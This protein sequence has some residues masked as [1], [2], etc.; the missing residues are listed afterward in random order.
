[1][2]TS[3]FKYQHLILIMIISFAALIRFFKLP[4]M[5]GFD[6]DQES[7][8]NIVYSIIKNDH[9]RLIG[10]ELTVGSIFMGPWYYYFLVPFYIASNLHPIGGITASVMFSLIIIYFYFKITEIIFGTNAGLLAAFIRAIT[11][12]QVVHDWS[13]IPSYGCELLVLFTWYLFYK[14]WNEK[15]S[16]L[17][18]PLMFIFGLYPSIYPILFPFYF[19]L[20]VLLILRKVKIN[21]SIFLKSTLAFLMPFFP[22]LIYEVKFGFPQTKRLFSI[23]SGRFTEEDLPRLIYHVKYNI[24]EIRRITA[25]YFVPDRIAIGLVLLALIIII[26]KTYPYLKNNFHATILFVTYIFF[27][28]SFSVLHAHV[29]ENYFLA[30]T[31]LAFIYI[32]VL[33]SHLNKGLW[34][35]FTIF[36]IVNLTFVNFRDYI[37]YKNKLSKTNLY[38]KEVIVK[39]IIKRSG[40]KNFYVSYIYTPG[41]E[42]GF[43]YLFKYYG[44]LPPEGQAK[45]PVYTIVIPKELAADSIDI[46]SGGVGLILPDK[47]GY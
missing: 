11:F 38:N 15:K 14:I 27:I 29:S 9:V 23:E 31:T 2:K 25:L 41:W 45:P 21:S 39:E 6:Y 42:L 1:M 28:V 36:I 12:E 40:G 22:T 3:K 35:I 24:L 46:S 18:V 32:S 43:K 8:S 5:A 13:M 37:T 16:R 26:I 44:K 47:N 4:E 34:K 19:I 17:L 7:G 20:P 33:M 30:L 10:Q